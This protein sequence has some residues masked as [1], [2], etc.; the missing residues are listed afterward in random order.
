[1]FNTLDTL[2]ETLLEQHYIAERGLTT[3]IFT[4]AQ[5]EQ[6]AASGRQ[7]GRRQD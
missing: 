3:A 5:T 4:G 7:G 6:T 1:M 2:Q